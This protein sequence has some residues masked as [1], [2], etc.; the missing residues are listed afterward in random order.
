MFELRTVS[1]VHYTLNH[2]SPLSKEVPCSTHISIQT[3][4]SEL[5]ITLK[6]THLGQNNIRGLNHV[7][8][9]LIYRLFPIICMAYAYVYLSVVQEAVSIVMVIRIC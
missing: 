7:T 5:K 6:H 9:E 8:M 3:P 4:Q 2:H 1:L